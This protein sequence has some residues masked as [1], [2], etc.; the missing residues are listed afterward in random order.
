MKYSH[1][2]LYCIRMVYY[3]HNPPDMWETG[4]K[5]SYTCFQLSKNIYE[6]L[7]ETL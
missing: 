7:P 1:Y 3:K 6:T 4:L 5:S 2:N